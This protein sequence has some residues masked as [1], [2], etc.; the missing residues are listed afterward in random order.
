[1]ALFLIA[2]FLGQEE[3]MRQAKLYLL[4]WH[5]VGQQPFAALARRVQG[6]DRVIG[7]CQEWI[8]EHYAESNP[9]AGMIGLSGLG[10]RTFKRR[11]RAATGMSPMDYVH[12]VRL[13]EA[14]QFLETTSMPV[15]DIA[16]EVGYGD[17][18]F[19]R[20]LFRRE[21]GLTPAQY[22]KQFGPIRQ[23]LKDAGKRPD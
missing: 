23:A 10:E 5:K 14:K 17:G 16:Q 11:F 3:A 20:R 22:R 7:V 8:A 4:D 21:V 13:E 19:F 1:M 9:V 12:T 18:S 2:R 6:E 15:E